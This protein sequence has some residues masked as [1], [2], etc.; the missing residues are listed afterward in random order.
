MQNDC[1]IVKNTRVILFQHHEKDLSRENLYSLSQNKRT[2]R[3]NLNGILKK[4]F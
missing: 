4:F 2:I 3:S 1:Y